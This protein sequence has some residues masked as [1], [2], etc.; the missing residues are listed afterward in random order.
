ML[1]LLTRILGKTYD[2]VTCADAARAAELLSEQL[3]DLLLTDVRMPVL[4]GMDLLRRAKRAQPQIEVVMMTAYGEVKQAVEAMREGAYDY[5]MKPFDS[6]EE[7]EIV[8]RKALE[9]RQLVEQTHFLSQEVK[10]KYSFGNIIGKSEAMRRTFGLTEKAVRSDSTVLL[11]GESGTG[12]ELF[13]RAIHYGSGRGKQ[14]FVPV[15]CGAIPREL[16]ESELFG[17]VKGA[18][19]GATSDKRGL[20]EEA[21][22]GSLFLDEICELPADVQ[23]KLT[24]AI[25]ERE[26]RAVG[27]TRDRKIDVRIIAA[28]NRN[29]RQ[30]VESG[31]FRE[32]LYFRISV[33]PIRVPPLRER[34]GDV[35]ILVAHFLHRS[36]E[37][38]ERKIERISADA[39]RLL[40]EHDWPGNVREL[41]NVI[42]RA[43]LL[44]EG[45]EISGQV[46][47]DGLSF[48]GRLSPEGRRAASETALLDLPYRE[49]MALADRRITREYLSGL[50]RR[51]GGSVTDA[52]AQAGIERVSFHRLMRRCGLKSEDFKSRT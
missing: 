3:F 52:A 29:L 44:E 25:Q 35:P 36:C 47:A 5:L 49:A 46:V 15:N 8:V 31:A 12:K 19:T 9:H 13:A 2:V 1:K 20:F 48:S 32:D 24:R 41:E 17:H 7:V 23:I 16:I 37:R 38:A 42:E 4:S 6:P 50:L 34:P 18:F 39:M 30:A 45:A 21:H 43:V 14:R 51:T 11:E 28:T 40:I 26:I 27:G 22:G 10:E 33:F